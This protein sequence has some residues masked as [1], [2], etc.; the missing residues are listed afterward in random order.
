MGKDD[1]EGEP[2]SKEEI[3]KELGDPAEWG[4]LHRKLEFEKRLRYGQKELD[5]K[6]IKGVP[7]T[8]GYLDFLKKELKHPIGTGTGLV[9]KEKNSHIEEQEKEAIKDEIKKYT[10]LLKELEKSPKEIERYL[11]KLKEKLKFLETNLLC[12]DLPLDNF[13]DTE[14]GRELA[15][16][17]N[18]GKKDNILKLKAA[19]KNYSDLLKR[20]KEAV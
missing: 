15:E 20:L 2:V 4:K 7:G 13:G 9:S 8:Q 18:W 10:K 3:L 19:I 11:R 14:E 5:I 16:K 17:L 6:G 1:L 12:V